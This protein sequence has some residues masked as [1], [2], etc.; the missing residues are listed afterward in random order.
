MSTVCFAVICPSNYCELGSP[1]AKDILVKLEHSQKHHQSQNTNPPWLRYDTKAWL[2]M[3]L[4][5]E[6][7]KVWWGRCVANNWGLRER[8]E[9][10]NLN[11]DHP[12]STWYDMAVLYVVAIS[13]NIFI[14]LNSLSCRMGSLETNFYILLYCCS[15]GN[16][17]VDDVPFRNGGICSQ[18]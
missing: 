10:P 2:S 7:L 4:W 14:A 3:Y 11:M 9:Y 17:L 16:N 1:T 15:Q 8:E 18:L 5:I 12:G 6:S 13:C